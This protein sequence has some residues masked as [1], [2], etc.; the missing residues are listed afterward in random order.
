VLQFLSLFSLGAFVHPLTVRLTTERQTVMLMA[1]PPMRSPA[2]PAVEAPQD[3]PLQEPHLMKSTCL[4]A[5]QSQH[6][7]SLAL[8]ARVTVV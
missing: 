3:P 8:P 5:L 7:P 1:L 2:A 6:L 4:T